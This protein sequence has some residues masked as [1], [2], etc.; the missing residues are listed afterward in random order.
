MHKEM[1]DDFA[2]NDRKELFDCQAVVEYAKPIL[3]N[4]RK[5]DKDF[6]LPADFLK[7]A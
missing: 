1:D 3:H 4:M 7:V 5:T 2:E 6:T